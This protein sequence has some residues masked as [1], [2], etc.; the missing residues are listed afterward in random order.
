MQFGAPDRLR[1]PGYQSPDRPVRGRKQSR[2]SH[3]NPGSE[4]SPSM[5]ASRPPAVV[6]EVETPSGSEDGLQAIQAVAI[7][8][9]RLK[10]DAH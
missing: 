6:S 7:F 3:P 8:R 10:A 9:R 2:A 5:P 1:L 4:N